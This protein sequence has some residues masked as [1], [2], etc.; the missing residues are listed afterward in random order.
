MGE[1]LGYLFAILAIVAV[2]V[3]I[4]VYVILPLIGI[5]MAVG[6]CYGAYIA[7]KNYA[8]AFNEFVIEGNKE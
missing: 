8:T 1:A 4:I 3:M 2:V 6:L 5:I 7:I